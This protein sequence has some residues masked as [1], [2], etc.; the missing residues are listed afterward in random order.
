MAT[1]LPT[2]D[3]PVMDENGK[4]NSV[5]YSYFRDI[6]VATGKQKGLSANNLRLQLN[7]LISTNLDGDINIIPNG[8]GAVNVSATAIQFLAGNS[9][10]IGNI[11]M[12]QTSGTLGQALVVV[13]T[14]TL[15]YAYGFITGDVKLSIRTDTIVGWVMMNDGTLGNEGSGATTY[16]NK[17]AKDLYVYLWNNISDTYCPV[18]GG[19]GSLAEV[20]FYLGKTIALP[21]SVGRSLAI[22]GS[23]SGLTT[24][25]LGETTGAESVVASLKNHSHTTTVTSVALTVSQTTTPGVTTVVSTIGETGTVTGT[26]GDG[27]SPATSVM[28]P[29]TFLNAYIKL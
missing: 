21:S 12:P 11:I 24:R 9:V 20:D 15:G 10:K 6:Y 25:A 17:D 16:A 23:G 3:T 14:D 13:D 26:S 29:T 22:F 28:Q 8:D 27:A 4:V 19:R 7:N 2:Q 1:L 5:W 18:S